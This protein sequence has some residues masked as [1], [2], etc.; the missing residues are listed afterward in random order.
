[1]NRGIHPRVSSGA[2]AASG[3]A[4]SP[5][6]PGESATTHDGPGRPSDPGRFGRARGAAALLWTCVGTSDHR[7]IA[8]RNLA[9]IVTLAVALGPLAFLGQWS[10]P[11]IG[12]SI[13]LAGTPQM[14]FAFWVL[15]PLLP[16]TIG[17]HRLPM[18]IGAERFAFPKLNSF[19]FFFFLVSA[20]LLASA[21]IE[22]RLEAGSAGPSD[23]AAAVDA[24]GDMTPAAFSSLFAFALLIGAAGMILLS[25]NILVTTHMCRAAG[26]RW[27]D[28][29]SFV[30]GL[31][32][33]ALV[34]LLTL[35]V[36]CLALLLQ[37][38]DRWMHF[39]LFDASLGGFPTLYANML[40]FAAH[41]TLHNPVLPAIGIIAAALGITARG[42]PAA[43]R[44]LVFGITS[45][46]GLSVLH[47]GAQATVRADSPLPAVASAMG[48]LRLIPAAVIV[49]AILRAVLRNGLRV[50][51][52]RLYALSAMFF[53]VVGMSSELLLRTLSMGSL[54]AD[55]SFAG[56]HL[57]VLLFGAV[58]SAFF[59]AILERQPRS[60]SWMSSAL[61]TSAAALLFFEGV[62]LAFFPDY[63]I[64]IR[65][66]PSHVAAS[67]G[68]FDR[69]QRIGSVGLWLI[70]LG[71]VV[72]ALVLV[73]TRSVSFAAAW[74]SVEAPLP[75]DK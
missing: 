12:V 19:A 21:L 64:G 8:R 60:R 33:A 43:H 49:A 73:R 27:L 7:R 58:G 10:D 72:Q 1:M 57:G 37:M 40:W 56:A 42:T 39:G 68:M 50:T 34:S 38:S 11:P 29:P 51:I 47:W 15:V 62:N 13:H 48:L 24:T 14:A 70:A 46:A 25:I 26:V 31:C 35:P 22:A 53:V 59:A 5:M 66:Y 18:M 17:M 41:P 4:P 45:L 3:G 74:R 63:L 71:V 28:L 55:S 61:W 75:R 44:I 69:L 23:S 65:G 32:C 9:L 54:L 20:A 16:A 52:P 6:T 30:W 67:L 36:G 2:G